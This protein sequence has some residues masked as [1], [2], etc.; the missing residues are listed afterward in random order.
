MFFNII[1]ALTVVIVV[2]ITSILVL[3]INLLLLIVIILFFRIIAI[4]VALIVGIFNPYVITFITINIIF[5]TG[6]NKRIRKKIIIIIIFCLL[7]NIARII[8][9]IF[10]YSTKPFW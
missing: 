1:I 2:I 4:T 6:V 3:I 8:I 7:M 9:S 5:I 10:I